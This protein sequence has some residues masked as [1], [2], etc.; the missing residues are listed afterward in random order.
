MSD[1]IWPDL[2]RLIDEITEHIDGLHWGEVVRDGFRIALIGAPNAGK[3][4]LLNRLADRDVAIVSSQPGT[5]RDTIE[6]RLDIGGY[7]VLVRDTAGLRETADEIEIEGI[8]RALNAARSSDLIL[9]LD[10]GS[11]V[12]RDMT[13]IEELI[14]E[15][16]N[17]LR[18]LT[19]ID[20]TKVPGKIPGDWL[21]VSAFT[22]EGV[23]QL[24]SRIGLEISK[25]AHHS[26]SLPNRSRHKDLLLECQ[27]HIEQS[28]LSRVSGGELAAADL[29]LASESLGRITG[30][31]GVEDLLG[32]IFS[33]FCVGK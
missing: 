21:G 26:T 3:S 14:S 31:V 13:A 1:Q 11:S 28:F 33:E 32:V 9:Y 7:L 6:V 15:G 20:V 25:K 22:G 16:A 17:I 24:I 2:Q 5:T 23:E 18:V 30:Q 4:T 29:K 8:R 19:K 27:S 10:D 12:G